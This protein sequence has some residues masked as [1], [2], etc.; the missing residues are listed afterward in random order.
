M[1]YK[2][3]L[4][5]LKEGKEKSLYLFY[6]NEKYLIDKTLREIEKLY[7][8]DNNRSFNYILIDGENIQVDNLIDAC[9][10]VPFIGEKRV[11]V[12]MD[13][14][15]FSAKKNTVNKEDDDRLIKYFSDIP[16]TTCLIFIE[17][18]NIDKRKKIV[19][20]IKKSGEIVEFNKLTKQEL[21]KWI[22]KKF[23]HSNKKA[24][25]KVINGFIDILGYEDRDSHKTLHDLENE[26]NKIS[27]YT[28]DK[29]ELIIEDIE[30]ILTKPIDTNIFG[31]VDAVAEKNGDLAFKI[32]NQ[33]LVA[34]E[35]EVKI[36]HMI[37]RQFKL[38]N[39]TKLMINKGYTAMA[40]SPKLSL[41]QHITK[42]YVK[43][44]AAFTSNDTLKI[45]NISLEMD[46]KIK[47]GKMSPRLALEILIAQCCEI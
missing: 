26:I 17:G 32:L 31:L 47:T 23:Q 6:G 25:F 42:K 16:D 8:N 11:V 41:P 22:Q 30:K 33:I 46:Q 18:I 44:S 36:L 7:I 24:S 29:S 10:T 34:G 20:E 28:D 4:K 40:I 9:E 39:T 37:A 21:G 15:L 1:T 38:I 45:L 43:Q 13:T 35:P 12:A 19:K 14:G 2:K 3:V 5:D 27:N